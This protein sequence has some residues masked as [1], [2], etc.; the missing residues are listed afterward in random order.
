MTLNELFQMVAF[1][2][3][4]QTRKAMSV[5]ALIDGLGFSAEVVEVGVAELDQQGLIRRNP[6]GDVVGSVGLSVDP[7]R[8]E[9]YVGD[10][11]F[12]T[13]CA[14]DAVGILAALEASGRVL[15]T[16]PLTGARIDVQ[17]HG[18]SPEASDVVL[19]IPEF[20]NCPQT[21][22]FEDRA[23][24]QA[25]AERRGVRGQIVSLAEAA[26]RGATHWRP[27]VPTTWRSDAAGRRFASPEAQP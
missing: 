21:N 7:S 1:Q 2:R 25:W 11:Q 6:S 22:L 10:Q 17:F 14:Y 23:A 4:L 15:S 13:W 9:L 19:F 3:L 18:G 8:H 16:S 24:S 12:W 26:T 27:I 20:F 5:A